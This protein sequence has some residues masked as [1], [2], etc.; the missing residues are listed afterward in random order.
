MSETFLQRVKNNP[1]P[2]VIF[3]IAFAAR[4]IYVIEKAV[5]DPAFAHPMVDELWHWQWANQILNTSFWGD[6]PYFRAPLYAYFLAFL[7]KLTNFLTVPGEAPTAQ[8]FTIRA[9]QCALAGYTAAL[10]YTLCQENISRRV[11][12]FTG[13]VY[14]LYAPL[15][16]Y[17]TMLLIPVLFLFLLAAALLWL[18]RWLREPSPNALYWAGLLFGLAGIARPNILLTMP[19][20][21]VL[22]YLRVAKNRGTATA[23][24]TRVGTF[25]LAVCIP[26]FAVTLRNVL[27]TGEATLIAT[28]GGINLYL[29]NNPEADGFTMAMPGLPPSDQLPWSQF[30]AWT[31]EVA[32]SKSGRKLSA[33]EESS[34]WSGEAFSW[35][36]ENPADFLK[37]SLK[38][39]HMIFLGYENSDNGNIYQN[40]EY[41]LLSRLTLW[42]SPLHFP[43]ALIV[44]LGLIGMVVQWRNKNEVAALY[45]LFLG[46]LP[47]VF[48]FLV[49]AR[50]RLPLVLF[51][52]PFAALGLF[53]LIDR[54]KQRKLSKA[55]PYG[56]A[57]V[58]L[59]FIS[60]SMPQSY[61]RGGF[62]LR[63]EKQLL[64]HQ[65]I[66][67]ERKGEFDVAEQAYRAAL[68][69]D[70]NSVALWNAL[71]YVQ[72]RQE[73]WEDAGK[74]FQRAIDL[75]PDQIDALLNFGQMLMAA[76]G[77]ERA[78]EKF[79]QASEIA[80]NDFRPLIN[81]GDVYQRFADYESAEEAFVRAKTIA[82]EEAD[83]HFKLGVMYAR[84]K[85]YFEAE[86]SFKR[87]D[88]YGDP[89]PIAL[90]NWGNLEYDMGKT[91]EALS[92]YE[93]A[94]AQAP[95]M[96][97]AWFGIGV[98]H[99]KMQSPAD[100]V[101]YYLHRAL[102]LDPN[103]QQAKDILERV[104][105]LDEFQKSR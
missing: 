75:A 24:L 2:W 59:I 87:G 67:Y 14:A 41:S 83:I 81:L 90:F 61:E 19:L 47:T 45:L 65:G 69:L 31:H 102:D 101:R 77:N 8:L 97:Q 68:Q 15:I 94:I 36:T 4:L 63:N 44:S 89:S 73:L 12:I 5:N 84:Q 30:T 25:T 46:Y 54:V 57:V 40:R 56:I 6:G 51:M 58:A 3:A 26:V 70:P 86:Q 17:E 91:R 38:K 93:R 9:L 1:W 16:Y 23:A 105:A 37:L 20:I 49:T 82:P 42:E 21:A 13:L 74:S 7:T 103:M 11:G 64:H 96:A 71:G 10:L 53:Y 22:L 95:K 34:F 43:W 80:P 62:G 33:A 29:G 39:L 48:L 78:L 18:F 32:E 52:L 27:V 72:W 100:T 55:L 66:A 88:Y 60:N 50:H 85:K 35:A 92:K 76:G 79:Q 99:F 28:Q 104:G 98:S